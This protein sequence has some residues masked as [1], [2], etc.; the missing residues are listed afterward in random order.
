MRLTMLAVLGSLATGIAV[1]AAEPTVTSEGAWELMRSDPALASERVC[2]LR[3]KRQS[4]IQVNGNTL[5]VTGL[6][7]NSIFNYQYRVDDGPASTPTIPTTDMQNAGAI[8]I[9][10][11]AFA[12][13]L[14][15]QRFRVRIL[16][17]WHE[18]ITEDIDLTG[19]RALHGTMTEACK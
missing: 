13:I 1:R 19:L 11:D 16:D 6:P 18:A 14:K 12:D 3:P 8:A 15:G 4:R 7:K 9:D 10:G 2:I 5:S 17:R